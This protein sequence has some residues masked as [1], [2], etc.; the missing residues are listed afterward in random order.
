MNGLLH[1]L[2][3]PAEITQSLMTNMSMTANKASVI[4]INIPREPH[5]QIK[6][7]ILVLVAQSGLQLQWAT[8]ANQ[9]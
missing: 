1:V 9:R 7:S 2:A 8:V 4:G 5:M 3:R 6:L